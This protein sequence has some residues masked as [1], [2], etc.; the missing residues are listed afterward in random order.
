MS[1]IEIINASQRESVV[2]SLVTHAEDVPGVT[3]LT[4]PME[5]MSSDTL[6]TSRLKAPAGLY[7]DGTPYAGQPASIRKLPAR[8]TQSIAPE[9]VVDKSNDFS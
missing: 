3:N 7:G 8:P 2:E 1:Y 5:A 4:Y 6:G 9:L